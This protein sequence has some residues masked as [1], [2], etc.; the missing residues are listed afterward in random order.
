MELNAISVILGRPTACWTRQECFTKWIGARDA[1][2]IE[3]IRCFHSSPGRR[4]GFFDRWAWFPWQVA[5]P[6]RCTPTVVYQ[7]YRILW[8]FLATGV[9][10]VCDE[11]WSQSWGVR[12]GTSNI[13]ALEIADPL[14]QV[15]FRNKSRHLKIHGTLSSTIPANC[16]TII[17][18]PFS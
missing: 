2:F 13:S 8:Q 14:R 6:D 3:T 11:L 5:W 15:V 12:N 7:F 4:G 10:S 16:F 1:C 18:N 17:I 9:I